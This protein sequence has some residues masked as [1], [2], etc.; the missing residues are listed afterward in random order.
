M[1]F[2]SSSMRGRD[3]AAIVVVDLQ[4]ECLGAAGDGLADAAHADDAE[5]L[6]PDAMAQ[7]PGRAPAGPVLVAGKH[8]APS[9]NR[10]GTARIS[11]MVMSAVSSV[12]T[13]GVL[14]T[15]MPRSQRGRDV[16]VVDAVAEIGD[17]LQLLAGVAEHRPVDRDR[18]PS[19]R[20]RRRL[21]H[22]SARSAWLI[23][24]SSRLRRVSNS[25]RMRV[26]TLSGSFRVTTTSG[27]LPDAIRCPAGC[28]AL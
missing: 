22:A 8:L 23:G 24:L 4:P 10:R 2:S 18:L 9:A 28:Q 1:A 14:V 26:S 6:A 11:A 5:P 16:D 25:S 3:A 27:F 20:S 19:A 12:S 15:V 13:P 7:H 17:Q 21:W